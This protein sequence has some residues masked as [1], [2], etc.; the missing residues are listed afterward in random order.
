MTTYYLDTSIAVDALF[1]EGPGALWFETVTADAT[2][3]IVSSRL[4]RTE[5]SRVLRREGR[6]VVER[7]LVLD[8]VDLV[9]LSDAIL[10]AAEAI[11]EHVKTLDAIHL[12]SALALG[13]S[14]VVASHDAAM[15]R[16]AALLGLR[17]LDPIADRS[18][19]GGPP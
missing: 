5:L 12:A 16:L 13:S 19:D 1:V 9:P 15:L 3:R 7:D 2:S 14:A 18:T 8:H 6:P 11:T 17:T 4:L 10:T